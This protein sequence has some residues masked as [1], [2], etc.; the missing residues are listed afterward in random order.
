[1]RLLLAGVAEFGARPALPATAG[2]DRY[3]RVRHAIDDQAIVEVGRPQLS[4]IRLHA[5]HV[6]GPL[7]T[8]L[9]APTWEGWSDDDCHTSLIPMGVTLVE[10]LLAE[11]VRGVGADRVLVP[12]LVPG[13]VPRSRGSARLI[14]TMTLRRQ[15]SSP[16]GRRPGFRNL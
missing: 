8:V 16:I 13:L 5:D 6:P 12:G 4:S 3:Q 14:V 15:V 10:R 7:P 9:Y 11:N 2:R 1:M